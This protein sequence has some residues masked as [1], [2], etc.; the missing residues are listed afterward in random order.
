MEPQLQQIREDQRASW[1]KFS[2][3]WKKW[4]SFLMDFLRPMGAAIIEE[5]K[6]RADDRILDIAAG[7][8]EP[9]LTI[10]ALVKNG[11]V[12]STDLSENMLAIAEET[13]KRRGLQN[14]S[15]Q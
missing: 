13:A 7:T 10:A 1:N 3:G 6:I 12:M 5:L 11:A 8:G 14:F 15:T 9:G 4:N 2:P